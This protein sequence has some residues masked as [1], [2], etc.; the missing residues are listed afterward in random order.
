MMSPYQQRETVSK[1]SCF[2]AY[3]VYSEMNENPQQ[4]P[5]EKQDGGMDKGNDLP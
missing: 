4:I 2:I 1:L 3:F 5:R